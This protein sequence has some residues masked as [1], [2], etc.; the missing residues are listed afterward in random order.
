MVSRKTRDAAIVRIGHNEACRLHEST[1]AALVERG[2]IIWQDG[3]NLTSKGKELFTTLTGLK[4][5]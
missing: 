5:I 1:Y 4:R 2:L 3:W